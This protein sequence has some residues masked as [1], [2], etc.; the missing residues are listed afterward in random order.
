MRH[1]LRAIKGAVK[2]WSPY[3]TP[4]TFRALSTAHSVHHKLH[5]YVRDGTAVPVAQNHEAPGHM[6]ARYYSP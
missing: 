6:M 5:T 4:Y 2:S 1:D 3:P